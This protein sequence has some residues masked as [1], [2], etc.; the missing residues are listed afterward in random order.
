MFS[1]FLYF[2]AALATLLIGGVY[3]TRK[4]VMPY[5]LQALESPWEEID[6]KYQYMLKA[7]LNGGGYFGFSTGLFMLTLL[8]IPFRA[9]EIWAGYA[10]GLIGLVGALP[11]GLIVRGVKTNTAGNPPLFVMVIINGLLVLGLV[12]FAFGR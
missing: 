11:L 12:A 4:T 8:L 6:P 10:I 7:L 2:V 9:G 1:F 3:A 5:H